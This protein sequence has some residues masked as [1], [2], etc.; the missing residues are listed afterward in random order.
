MP[1]LPP[2]RL[3]AFFSRWEFAARHHLTA[4]D[5]ETM[6]LAELVA[7]ASADDRAAWE[8]LSLGYIETWGTRALR[9]AIA[10][11]YDEG[12]DGQE[13][14]RADDILC[15]AGAEEGLYCA[16]HALLSPGDH[17]VIVVP[18]Y[19]AMETVPLAACGSA[20]GVPLR[21]ENDWALDI[22]EVRRALRPNTRVVAIN[23]PHNP[24]GTVADRATFEALVTL[25]RE[26]GVW[27]FSDEVYRGLERDPARRLP[28]AAAVY[29]RGLSLNVLSKA[30]GLPGLR[31]GWIAG[32]DRALLAR[33]EG[34]KH[35][36]S[37]CNAG[38]SELLAR[39]ALANREEIL[40]RNLA[41]CEANLALLQAFFAE[42]AD[43]YAW[44]APPGGCTG[45][46]RY[47]GADGVEAHC[48]ALVEDAGVLLLPASIYRSELG[49]VP[50]DR[51][52]VGFGRAG[53]AEGLAAWRS[54][55]VK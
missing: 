16:L 20:T 34:M 26:R 2:F 39:I 47:L 1:T 54:Y 19:Q 6:R 31:V 32:R 40:A 10:A 8:A 44:S 35:Y 53:L 27:L 30:Y 5:A 22:D 11:T 17:A 28:Q 24:T 4:S 15:F 13:P 52:R 23:F 18:C 48:R 25:C 36:L 38:P 55:L 7:L 9:E 29:E 41:R 45:F 43:R 49:D 14:L 37:I 12:D 21:P 46:P 33:M 50:S 42:H 51:F 3:E